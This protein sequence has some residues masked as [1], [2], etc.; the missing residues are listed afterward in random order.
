[1]RLP[2]GIADNLSGGGA[3]GEFIS[4]L[5]SISVLN[6][7]P[8][9]ASVYALDLAPGDAAL[10]VGCGVGDDV[11]LLAD[12][13]G[14]TGCAVGIDASEA[15]LAEA[16]ARTPPGFGVEF[17][18]ADVHAMPFAKDSFA[19]ARV[20]R[21]LQ[22]VA[23]PLAVVT[24][25]A[26]VVRPGGLIV[27]MEPDW[28]TLVVSSADLETSRAVVR[29]CADRIRHPDAGRRLPEWFVRAEIEVKRVDALATPI[30]SLDLAEYVFKLVSA[31]ESLG[32]SIAEP[33]LEELRAREAHGACVVAAT[34]FGVIGEV[35]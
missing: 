20:E 30:R 27:A 35:R 21:A 13:V 15:L 5:D 31:V 32:R 6:R 10:D 24:E 29:A 7:A 12:V 2:L 3:V 11:R 8:K 9:K 25:M 34:G 14:P 28:D 16:R 1:V 18:A 26:R 33:W 4:Y 17:V 23:D 19:A 22:H